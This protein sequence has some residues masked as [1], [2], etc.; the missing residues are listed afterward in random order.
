M[1][2]D[3]IHQP[4]GSDDVAMQL[5]DQ[6]FDDYKAMYSAS[7][8]QRACIAREDVDGLQASVDRIRVIMDRIRLRQVALQGPE[9][10]SAASG[11]VVERT[12]A[13]RH[14]IGDL[15]AIREDN[16]GSVRRL[17]ERSR[18]EF[19]QFQQSRRA[20]RGY[21]TKRAVEEARFYDLRR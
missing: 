5:L 17:M 10:A 13:I 8:S 15:Q 2:T 4:G 11:E 16:E 19:E 12:E 21:A 7:V 9:V 6:Q 14:L 18:E 3:L 20:T 1:S